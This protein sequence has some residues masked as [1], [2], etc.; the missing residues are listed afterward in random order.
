M[1]WHTM[2]DDPAWVQAVTA[3]HYRV[4]GR[5]V[6]LDPTGVEAGDLPAAR[7]SVSYDCEK[8]ERT[9]VDLE[10]RDPRLVPRSVFSLLDPRSGTRV[11]VLWRVPGFDWIPLATVWLDDPEVS[12]DADQVSVSVRGHDAVAHYRRGGYGGRTVTLSGMTVSVALQTLFDALGVD[13]YEVDQA[14]TARV[15]ASFAVGANEDPWDDVVELAKLGG[16]EV[17]ADRMGV[18]VARR[19]VEPSTARHQWQEG[20]NC[21]VVALQRGLKTASIRNRVVAVSTNSEVV[22][23]VSAVVQ[24][25]DPSSPTYVFGRFGIRETRIESDK[26]ADVEGA[27]NMARATFERWRYAREDLTVTI[28]QRGDLEGHDLAAVS[29]QRSGASG[30]W[31]IRGWT[32]DLP[33]PGEDPALMR[34]TMQTRSTA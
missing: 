9:A 18:I 25:D 12:E 20:P 23:P 27:R 11:R 14:A 22:P 21:Q 24:D 13:R 33:A 34:V 16:L 6:V 4:E 28:R 15:P 17:W 30:L 5:V 8:A 31:R 32:V 1:G 26:I 19:L 7:C 10:F 29:S 2:V 3:R